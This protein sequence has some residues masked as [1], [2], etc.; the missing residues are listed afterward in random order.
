MWLVVCRHYTFY[1]S[2][3]TLALKDAQVIQL[4]GYFDCLW[5][6]SG[7]SLE[8]LWT[9]FGLPQDCLWTV[10]VLSL[11]MTEFCPKYDSIC[12][13]SDCICTNATVF[14]LNMTRF[15]LNMAGFV[16]I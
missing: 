10:S 2:D 1:S 5:T 4:W 15:A 13:K 16:Q 11:N 7:L 12:H 3:F 9:V 6:S 14:V 8:C